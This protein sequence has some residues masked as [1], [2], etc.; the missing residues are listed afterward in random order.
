MTS[1][2]PARRARAI[3]QAIGLLVEEAG[4]DAV[5][6]CL[7]SHRG[8]KTETVAVPWGNLHAVRGIAEYA[9]DRLVT[10]DE[11]GPEE[12]AGAGG[13]GPQEPQDD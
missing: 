3:R 5:L 8:G 11:E 4:A 6:I 12:E 10:Q 13:N 7:T 1:R 9:Y 2:L